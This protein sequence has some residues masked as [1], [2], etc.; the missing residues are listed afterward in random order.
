LLFHNL[1]L[2]RKRPGNYGTA[3]RTAMR[4]LLRTRKI[5]T[6]KHLLQAGYLVH[7]FLPNSG[8]VH[9]HAHFAHS[10]TSVALFASQLSGLDFSFTAHAK[11]IYTSD[12]RQLREKIA[13]ARFVVTCTEYNMRFLK[14]MSAGER[15][16]I[17]RLYHGIDSDFFS[18]DLLGKN[19]EK[20]PTP[21][22]R[23]LTIARITAKKG[24]PTVYRALKILRDE[25][26][27]FRHTLIG[28]GEDRERIL[29]LIKELGLDPFTQ[30]LG[31]Q[32]HEVVLEH[33]RGADVFVL[34]C[35]VAPNG[36][37]DGIPNVL[38]ESMAVGVPVV[39]TGISAIPELVV[40]GETGLLVPPAE[41]EKMARALIQL[42]TDIP[43]RKQ[44]IEAARKR[45]L[46]TFDNHALIGGLAA[47]YR[48]EVREFNNQ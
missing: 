35:E 15:T 6:I 31:T 7:R 17:H 46:Q 4:R 48:Q 28:D 29:S 12:P 2:A 33:Y 32:P 5:A 45:V 16:P 19:D 42:L 41:P 3:L 37:R 40:E 27:S 36:D 23:I 47:V 25:G 22:Y 24:L 43:L 44:V 20:I 38:L 21:P 10:P 26:I 30:L 9:L 34:G 13:Q 8:V 14:K 18:R 1:L 39:A 11:D